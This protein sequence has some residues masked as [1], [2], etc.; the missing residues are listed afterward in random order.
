[1]DAPQQRSS[2]TR[3]AQLVRNQTHHVIV[4]HGCDG[5][6]D[7]NAGDAIDND[8]SRKGSSH[9]GARD[10]DV[11]GGMRSDDERTARDQQRRKQGSIGQAGAGATDT[12]GRA[13]V[14]QQAAAG[15]AA[16]GQAAAGKPVGVHQ[17]SRG[18]FMAKI[19][20][21]KKV[22]H[23][24]SFATS[25][26]AARAYDAKAQELT[27]QDG[28]ARRLNYGDMPGCGPKS[29]YRGVSWS[30]RDRRWRA[31][32]RWVQSG[33]QQT[34]SSLHSNEE[35]A[36]RACDAKLIEVLGLDQAR[37]RLNFPPPTDRGQPAA[38]AQDAAGGQG[39]QDA[40]TAAPDS[41]H[42]YEHTAGASKRQQHTAA[43]HAHQGPCHLPW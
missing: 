24:G 9:S 22:I 13:D 34:A 3:A 12:A 42:I 17:Q 32:I 29:R 16:A 2:L 15:Q 43:V 7:G 38:A 28:K 19:Q 40:D 30:S 39:T 6:G 26:A 18:T 35:E 1:M 36:A 31:V 23:L 27:Q 37:S 21:M 8:G 33:K 25:E 14:V 41:V 11:Q 4:T 5:A 10:S 20:V